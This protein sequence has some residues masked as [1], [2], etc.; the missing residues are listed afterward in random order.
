M[1]ALPPKKQASLIG[2][3]LKFAPQPNPAVFAWR[4]PHPSSSST[5]WGT[6]HAALAAESSAQAARIAEGS[7]SSPQGTSPLFAG[8][9]P[10]VP[11]RPPPRDAELGGNFERETS[12]GYH[13]ARATS[14]GGQARRPAPGGH[15]RDHSPG[16][17][18]REHPGGSPYE[19]LSSANL[20]EASPGGSMR[21]Q[22]PAGFLPEAFSGGRPMEQLPGGYSREPSPYGY[23][24]PSGYMKEPSPGGHLREHIPGGFMREAS[25]GGHLREASPGG[26]LREHI[27]GGFMREASPGGHLREASPGG[28][29]WEHTPGGF[30][31]EASPGGHLREA[32]TGGH[33]REHT[34]GGFMR[35]ASPG[36]NPR[37]ASPGGLLPEAPAGERVQ[38]PSGAAKQKPPGSMSSRLKSYLRG[39]KKPVSGKRD[40]SPGRK[41][42]Q[43]STDGYEEVLP[44]HS[45]D[46]PTS[47]LRAIVEGSPN[48]LSDAERYEML[49]EESPAPLAG[50]AAPIGG[51]PDFGASW[52]LGG[53]AA[54]L[55]GTQPFLSRAP[56]H[57]PEPSPRS[58][59]LL[60]MAAEALEH[61][62][63][64]EL[65]AIGLLMQEAL[66][67]A[68]QD[69]A[70]LVLVAK[71]LAP[72]ERSGLKNL[73]VA[74]RV[75]AHELE[76]LLDHALIEDGFVD[77]FGTLIDH[78]RRARPYASYLLTLPA[79]EFALGL[80]FSNLSCAAPYSDWLVKDGIGMCVTLAGF[81]CGYFALSNASSSMQGYMVI[82]H[83]LLSGSAGA[84]AG[85]QT[86]VPEEHHLALYFCAVGL[87]VALL[88]LLCQIVWAMWG[89]LM[90]LC[91][92]FASCNKAV[93]IASRIIIL[94]KVFVVLSSFGY[95][96][97]QT[98]RMCDQ[99]HR[100]TSPRVAGRRLYYPTPR[101]GR[102]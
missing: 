32:S 98:K 33:L 50:G 23:T 26:H 1:T 25:P 31:R 21:E 91:D 56:M 83:A 15:L 16:G 38:S 51:L 39:E 84:G 43:A 4:R 49:R 14:P 58:Q 66:L 100:D 2:A 13:F 53:G 19:Q 59:Q 64:Q 28:H 3:A 85:S 48:D 7:P 69:P 90:W 102:K 80:I 73:L 79:L 10:P 76:F 101:R 57:G 61:I 9:V 54:V 94:A 75:V 46:S 95:V 17:F 93:E 18:M 81:F 52:P 60:L 29:L 41:L 42:R 82:S 24:A 34:P 62:P 35:E 97:F 44:K 87:S 86:S 70:N 8:E 55:P 92:T 78:L 11:W 30:M 45:P 40:T 37:E 72:A 96:V 5:A 6:P 99:M 65:R 89:L 27:P 68:M 20:R 71:E 77:R 63:A 12:P 88:G 74:H 36:R 47:R 22:A 67:E